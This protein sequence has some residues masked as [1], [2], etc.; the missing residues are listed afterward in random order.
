MPRTLLLVL[1]SCAMLSA[2]AQ[3]YYFPKT[4]YAD[5]VA[6]QQQLPTLAAKVAACIEAKGNVGNLRNLARLYLLAG[7]DAKFK[8]WLDSFVVVN[9]G[10]VK[11]NPDIN[12]ESRIF[13]TVR[14]TAKP[15]SKVFQEQY[16]AK[17]KSYFPTMPMYSQ[18][19][20]QF[21]ADREVQEFADKYQDQLAKSRGSDSLSQEQANAFC[22]AYINYRVYGI[23]IPIFKQYVDQI[24]AA[25]YLV[26]D[27]ILITAPDGGKISLTVVRNKQVKGPQPVILKNN[28]Y[29]G[30]DIALAKVAVDY[31]YIGVIANPRGKRLS[32]DNLYPFEFDVADGYTVIDWISKQPWCNGKVGMYG[33]SYLGFTQWAAVKKLHPALKTI[34][35][36]VAVAPGIDFPVANGVFMSN[37]LRWIHYVNNNKNLDDA[38]FFDAKK[39]N[40]LQETWYQLGLPFNRLDSLEGKSQ[41]LFQ[42]WL[43]H[44]NYDD[45]WK[46]VTPQG[47]EFGK[48]KIPIFFTTGYYEGDQ[49][50]AI[51]YWKQLQAW[52]KNHKSYL[53]MGPWTHAGAQGFPQSELL[54]YKT[55]P[56]SNI[57]IE[58]LIFEW[59]DHILKGAALPKILKGKINFQVMGAN[60]W[61]TA[62]SLEGMYNDSLVFYPG[63]AQQNSNSYALS[64]KP[65]ANGNI[66]QSVDF[67]F[68]GENLSERESEEDLNFIIDSAIHPNPNKLVFISE[69][70]TKAVII[71]GPIR[72]DL[73]ARIN[74]KDM[75]L[76]LELYE[77]F[78][79]GRVMYLN[80]TIHR[81]SYTQGPSERRLLTPGKWEKISL[82]ENFQAVKRLS[83]GSRIIIRLGIN[84]TP[85][86]QINYGTGRDVSTE[87]ILDAR[88]PLEID[89]SGET[90]F[91]VRVLK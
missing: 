17:L 3:T 43:Q 69:P 14:K 72:A 32:P 33:G 52:N 47:E 36:A 91:V 57:K 88:E 18:Q 49:L 45:Y 25:K 86:W 80:K 21:L 74:K 27:S 22:L 31:G 4:I 55:D 9:V 50:G 90:R 56:V 71:S 30:S 42:R 16:R 34:V 1:F 39:W 82:T 40:K 54:G 79:D 73:L 67:A 41:P 83:P 10:P 76:I 63:A 29:T 20:A 38:S 48:I 35:P 62:A 77:Q 7:N 65:L 28:I 24:T 12:M 58:P 85:D 11:E 26:N 87:S 46:S 13:A 60:E 19:N 84:K 51:Y 2:K 78:A 23:A 8:F 53:L 64:T 44:P 37:M 5:S 75:D 6:L 70:V 66:H 61:R 81:A 15:G 89:W 68:R 59:F